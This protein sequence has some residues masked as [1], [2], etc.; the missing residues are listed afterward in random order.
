MN[1]IGQTFNN[2]ASATEQI[3]AGVMGTS[4]RSPFSYEREL[5]IIRRCFYPNDINEI[6]ERLK[7]EQNEFATQCLNIMEAS[8]PIAMKLTLKIMRESLKKD[9]VQTAMLELSAA[10]NRVCDKEF[11]IALQAK[12]SRSDHQK[13][14]W[15][16][17]NL[18]AI[19]EDHI[20]SYLK[21][22]EW[23]TP[24]SLHT[25]ENAFLPNREFYYFLPDCM[26]LWLNNESF[27]NSGTR[28]SFQGDMKDALK[29]SGFDQRDSGITSKSLREELRKEHEIER[30]T[31]ENERRARDILEDPKLLE[32]YT[33]DR[34]EL[35]D[36]FCGNEKEYSEKMEK[37]I[38]A[39][40]EKVREKSYKIL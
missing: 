32:K 13:S 26:R 6:M 5:G 20:L 29:A 7:M 4:F 18:K 25:V 40:F 30:I 22:P 31:S 24:K 34:Q 27:V 19:S 12:L 35:I 21:R 17:D 16:Y 14:Y 1:Y 28:A 2:Y 39:I 15:K 9:Y 3:K 8:S 38:E 33:R 10:L 37:L 11:P 23:L 36:E